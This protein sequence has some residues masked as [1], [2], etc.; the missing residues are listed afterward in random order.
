MAG[1]T[2]T[3]LRKERHMQHTKVERSESKGMEKKA[4]ARKAIH[5]SLGQEIEMRV[6]SGKERMDGKAERRGNPMVETPAFDTNGNVTQQ[7]TE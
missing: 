7:R 6:R 3:R 4:D 1:R 2:W 5:L